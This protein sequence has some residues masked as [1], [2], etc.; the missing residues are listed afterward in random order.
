MKHKLWLRKKKTL[1]SHC[2]RFVMSGR[3]QKAWVWV[4]L[5]SSY[6]LQLIRRWWLRFSLFIEN[7]NESWINFK[8]NFLILGIKICPLMQKTNWN[9]NFSIFQ[10]FLQHKTFHPLLNSCPQRGS[11]FPLTL[12][13][14]LIA[15]THTLSHTHSISSVRRLIQNLSSSNFS[16]ANFPSWFFSVKKIKT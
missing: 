7:S 2:L 9:K 8:S 6:T 13:H 1:W 5:R 16:D 3:T 15:V 14:T 11:Y 12:T 10:N 4:P